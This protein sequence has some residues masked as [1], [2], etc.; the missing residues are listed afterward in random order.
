MVIMLT[1]D[2]QSINLATSFLG[3]CITTH[4]YFIYATKN[5]SFIILYC[6]G[7]RYN[8]KKIINHTTLIPVRLQILDYLFLTIIFTLI[9]IY[10]NIYILYSFYTLI[11]LSLKK[12]FFPFFSH[13]MIKSN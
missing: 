10:H 5:M 2:W 12:L 7:I 6:K 13:Q 11:H 9:F 4:F 8:K 3:N 1:Q